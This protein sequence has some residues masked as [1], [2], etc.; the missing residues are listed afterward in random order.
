MVRRPF[1]PNDHTVVKFYAPGL[2]L[3]FNRR[4]DG[5]WF[6]DWAGGGGGEAGE[7]GFGWCLGKIAAGVYEAVEPERLVAAIDELMELERANVDDIIR[8]DLRDSFFDYRV[9]LAAAHDD[10]VF[11]FMFFET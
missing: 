7:V 5:E 3:P 4:W 6:D 1:S 9:T 11:V 10:V 2:C 8:H